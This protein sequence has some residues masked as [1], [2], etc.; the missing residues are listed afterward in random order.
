MN[1]NIYCN[2]LINGQV[3]MEIIW[4]LALASSKLKFIKYISMYLELHSMYLELHWTFAYCQILI[5]QLLKKTSTNN[6][7]TAN[8]SGCMIHYILAWTLVRS[9]WHLYRL[10]MVLYSLHITLLPSTSTFRSSATV[11]L[12]ALVLTAP[13]SSAWHIWRH[14]GHCTLP[15]LL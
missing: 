9:N 8:Y 13:I 5:H 10:I 15:A 11:L 7:T 12:V 6:I 3:G 1:R 2:N 4:Q 14:S